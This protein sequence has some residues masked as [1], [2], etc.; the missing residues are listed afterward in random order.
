[1][2]CSYSNPDNSTLNSSSAVVH[3]TDFYFF[4]SILEQLRQDEQ[5]ST[6][7]STDGRSDPLVAQLNVT[8]LLDSLDL[9]CWATDPVLYLTPFTW[10]PPQAG[11]EEASPHRAVALWSLLLPTKMT[12][13]DDLCVREKVR[14]GRWREP[15]LMSITNTFHFLASE[16]I[17]KLLIHIRVSKQRQYHAGFSL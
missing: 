3:S 9:L 8:S 7:S 11:R 13:A 15:A 14:E 16:L 1:M 10:R 6:N 4:L 5:Q 17:L 12:S 2:I